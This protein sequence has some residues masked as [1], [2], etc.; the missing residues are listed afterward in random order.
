MRSQS[1]IQNW[2][3]EKE[4]AAGV[5]AEEG[6]GPVFEA[7]GV[8][9]SIGTLTFGASCEKPISP[10]AWQK[11]ERSAFEGFHTGLDPTAIVMIFGKAARD[12]HLQFV[13]CL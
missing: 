3:C 12:K 13:L 10:I 11:G 9:I 1:S 2:L 8:A 4:C 7:V 6:N 5:V